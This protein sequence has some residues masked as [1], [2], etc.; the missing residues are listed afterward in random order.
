MSAARIVTDSCVAEFTV[1]ARG[2]PS[3]WTV[4]LA[5]KPVPVT[6]SAN[7]GPPIATDVGAIVV[8]V[9]VGAVTVSESGDGAGG[10]FAGGRGIGIFGPSSG[11][12]STWFA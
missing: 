10:V 7:V 6:V 9:G 12:G 5:T 8:S 3:T 2:A 4:E 1:V 11:D